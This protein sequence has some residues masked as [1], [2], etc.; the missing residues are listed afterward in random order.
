LA[1]SLQNY[2]FRLLSESRIRISSVPF[3]DAP[4]SYS[5]LAVLVRTASASAC[6]YQ[7]T[8]TTLPHSSRGS[9]WRSVTQK[10]LQATLQSTG[11]HA[12]FYNGSH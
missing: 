1:C 6:T 9:I 3:L 7:P 4:R 11:L 12:M 8:T 5:T 10:G 2:L